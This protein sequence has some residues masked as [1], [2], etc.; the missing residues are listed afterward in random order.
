[1]L[2]SIFQWTITYVQ[3]KLAYECNRD[4]ATM[5]VDGTDHWLLFPIVS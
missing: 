1:M 4:N 3:T 2:T 5:E